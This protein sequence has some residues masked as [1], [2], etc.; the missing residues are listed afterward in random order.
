[1][2]SHIQ[3]RLDLLRARGWFPALVLGLALVGYWDLAEF[4]VEKWRWF[5][6]TTIGIN[7]APLLSSSAAWV[8]VSIIWLAWLLVRPPS[9]MPRLYRMKRLLREAEAQFRG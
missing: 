9:T 8:L 2:P 5:A 6:G 1:V 4:S 3:D 7:V